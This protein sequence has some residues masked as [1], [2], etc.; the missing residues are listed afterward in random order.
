MVSHGRVK[1]HRSTSAPA[2]N[3]G[4]HGQHPPLLRRRSLTERW[5]MTSQTS[6]SRTPGNGVKTGS[7]RWK[8]HAAGERTEH[9]KKVFHL[10]YSSSQ[11]QNLALN[12]VIVTNSLDSG[13]DAA[14]H[15]RLRDPAAT[16]RERCC[17]NWAHESHVHNLAFNVAYVLEILHGVPPLLGSG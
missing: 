4:G 10:K 6:A 9:L 3:R 5:H 12:V 16:S 8:R 2:H 17:A 1:P 14:V 11:G 7:R 15:S 13:V